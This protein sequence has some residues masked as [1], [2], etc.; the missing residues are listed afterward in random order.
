VEV[1]TNQYA[2]V[3]VNPKSVEEY[4]PLLDDSQFF[5]IGV[6]CLFFL[7]MERRRVKQQL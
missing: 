1:A 2:V 4:V 3:H 5:F 7:F 6:S